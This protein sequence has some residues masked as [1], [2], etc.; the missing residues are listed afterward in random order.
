MSDPTFENVAEQPRPVA[1]HVLAAIFWMICN[2]IGVYIVAFFS[3]L[4]LFG[5]GV[6]PVIQA[7]FGLLAGLIFSATL[8]KFASTENGEG[9]WSPPADPILNK[10]SLWVLAS[11][12]PVIFLIVMMI[13]NSLLTGA[14]QARF[15]PAPITPWPL[16]SWTIACGVIF[17]IPIAEESYFRGRLWEKIEAVGGSIKAFVW[18]GAIFWLMHLPNLFSGGISKTTFANF[19][20]LLP[21]TLALSWLRLKCGSAR[22]TIVLHVV[23][24]FVAV[25][26]SH[27]LRLY[28]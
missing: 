21:L 15:S 16:L 10:K 25:A 8:L 13:A 28:F 2:F 11:C 12:W 17:V 20:A 23:H 5:R 9:F 24:N 18:T 4:V 22:A 19:L 27:I 26:P 6:D 14:F 3:F 7:Q 1:D